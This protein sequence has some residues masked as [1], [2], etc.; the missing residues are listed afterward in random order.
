MQGCNYEFVK[1]R[2]IDFPPLTK[3][4]VR[5]GLKGI[6]KLRLVSSFNHPLPLLKKEGDII[7]VPLSFIRR[8]IRD[9]INSYSV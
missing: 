8:G 4:R 2:E 1:V 6:R 3:G 5:E 7:Y 9:E